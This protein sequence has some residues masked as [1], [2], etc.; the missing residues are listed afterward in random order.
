[1]LGEALQEECKARFLYQSVLGTFGSDTLPF[2]P[3]AESEARHVDALQIL[4]TRRQLAPQASIWTT[5]SF[6]PFASVALACAAGVV[7]ETEDAAFYTPYLQRTDLPADVR[8]VFTN[9]QAA[10][11]DNHLPVFAR[12]R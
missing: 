5:S 3:I 2:A 11:L 12:C 10:S 6:E 8:N 9:L 7:A 1:M 4:F